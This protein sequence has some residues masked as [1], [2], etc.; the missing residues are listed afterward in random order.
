MTGVDNSGA[1]FL[2]AGYFRRASQVGGVH[3][4][5]DQR[6]LGV[7][8]ALGQR[9]GRVDSQV[10]RMTDY[11]DVFVAGGG[12]AGL[13]AAIAAR[14]KGFRVTVADGAAPPVDKAC[15]EGMMPETLAALRSLGVNISPC[16][17]S[18]FPGV[19]FVQEGRTATASFPHGQG[20]GLRR[21][22]LHQKLI[23]RAEQCGVELLWKTPM[24]GLDADG[25]SAGGRKIR[26]RWI[27]G[28]DGLGSRVRRW[29]DLDAARSSAK[30]YAVRRHYHVRAW[31][32][33]AEV[34]WGERV[35]AYVTPIG[36]DEVCVV[37]IGER[38][39]DAAFERGLT[40]LPELRE[41]LRGAVPGSRERGAVTF[42]KSLRNVQRGNV[43]LI[44]DASGSV[45]AITGEGLRLAFHQ[46]PALAE[47][48]AAGSL[49]SYQQAHRE[50]EKRPMIMGRLMLLLA[51][52]PALRKRVVASFSAKPQL[53]ARLLALHLGQ[54]TPA[55][56]L[57][58]GAEL[59]WQLLVA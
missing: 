34:H 27:V 1:N 6:L 11:V 5:K 20:I 24:T 10:H 32:D 52:R 38:G 59:G 17:G 57:T 23:A 36:A 21:P 7:F 44:G 26:A 4:M 45:D 47:A 53:F 55:E 22:L 30:R 18:R 49:R 14:Q 48:M 41:R 35:Q 9:C 19:R 15:G 25:V 3:L 58:T 13:A 46:A 39:E 51:R 12:P 43:A 40:G 2:L 54:G 28:A 50:L 33:F 42:S 29:S 37:M 16:E 8:L 31:T 56:V